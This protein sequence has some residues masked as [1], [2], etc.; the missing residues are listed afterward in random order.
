MN[1]QDLTRCYYILQEDIF[2]FKKL[3]LLDNVSTINGQ[4]EFDD[5]D[6]RQIIEMVN[7]MELGLDDQGLV[8]YYTNKDTQTDTLKKVRVSILEQLHSYQKKLD[9][10]DYMIYEKE[11]LCN[12]YSLII[13]YYMWDKIKL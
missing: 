10:I 9:D 13:S 7:L 5:D 2:K 8:K 3:G 1:I 11:K 12:Y 4:M 6:V